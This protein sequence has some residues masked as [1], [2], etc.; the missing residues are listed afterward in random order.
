MSISATNS[1]FVDSCTWEAVIAVR[2]W[3]RDRPRSPNLDPELFLITGIPGSGKTTYGNE[4]ARMFG[5]AHYDLENQQTLNRLAANPMQFI[6]NNAQ[7]GGKAVVTW[8]FLPD[9][10]QISIVEQFKSSGFKLIWLDGNR[11]AALDRFDAR[12]KTKS[13]SKAEY[14]RRMHEFY[15]Q[16]YR[17][18]TSK[19]I[20]TITPVITNPFDAQGQ[21]KSAEELLQELR[22]S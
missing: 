7:S 5:F 8:G 6:D 22:R 16:M 17:I 18:E 2:S 3:A 10:S 15:L 12:A 9:Q 4:F 14:Y 19:V 21:F 1:S 11:Q 20:E 13:S